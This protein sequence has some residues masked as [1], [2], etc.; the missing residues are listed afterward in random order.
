MAK[1]K[2]LLEWQSP[3]AAAVEG[4]TDDG[5]RR[6]GG[7]RGGLRFVIAAARGRKGGMR[8]RRAAD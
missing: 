8:R 4:A 2:V 5:D 3:L 1:E 6:E 7:A